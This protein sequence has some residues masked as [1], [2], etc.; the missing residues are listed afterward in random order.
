MAGTGAGASQKTAEGRLLA[1]FYY[2]TWVF[3]LIPEVHIKAKV[4]TFQMVYFSMKKLTN[5]KNNTTFILKTLK[6]RG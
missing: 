3:T 1:S 2:S 5:P 6:V 4:G